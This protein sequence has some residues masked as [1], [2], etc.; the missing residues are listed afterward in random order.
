MYTVCIASVDTLLK[1]L[2]KYKV[3]YIDDIKK[4][5]YGNDYYT[6]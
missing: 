4:V 3:E 1:V 6:Y 5:R 2:E